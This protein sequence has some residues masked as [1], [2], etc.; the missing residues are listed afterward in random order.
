MKK[1]LSATLVLIILAIFTVSVSAAPPPRI[2]IRGE[3][4]LLEIRKIA[5]ADE[6][7]L[8]EYLLR[9]DYFIN[10]LRSREDLI[11]FLELLDSLPILYGTGMHFRSLTYYPESKRVNIFFGTEIGEVHSYYYFLDENRNEMPFPT[12]AQN[13]NLNEHG[14]ISFMMDIE[15]FNISV[16]YNRGRNNEHILTVNPKEMYSDMI[17]TSFR[18]EPWRTIPVSFT[19][20]DALTI[21]RAVAGLTTLTDAQVARYGISGEPA[22]AD[23]VAVLRIVAG[24]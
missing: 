17:I 13:F 23:A 21:L 4:S 10:G 18:E 7:V 24:L 9:T 6:E 16:G 8:K 22:A 2:I 1:V 11:S 3:E 19:T 12:E 5:E 15:G 20:A 14:A